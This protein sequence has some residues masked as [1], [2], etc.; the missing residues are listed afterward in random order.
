M[1]PCVQQRTNKTVRIT[2]SI[3]ER[4]ASEFWDLRSV[5]QRWP[6]EG[7]LVAQQLCQECG[8]GMEGQRPVVLWRVGRGAQGWVEGVRG[9]GC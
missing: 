1:G 6:G 9:F 2:R 3:K 4:W 8:G 7:L 5:G